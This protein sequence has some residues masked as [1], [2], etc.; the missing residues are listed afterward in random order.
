MDKKTEQIFFELV[1]A[2]RLALNRL[3]S[4]TLIY[5]PKL[6]KVLVAAIENSDEFYQKSLQWQNPNENSAYV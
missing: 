2:C 1:D 5:N 4:L 3:D 6:R